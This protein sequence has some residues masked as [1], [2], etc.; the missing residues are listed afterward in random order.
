MAKLTH[1]LRQSL[2]LLCRGLFSISLEREFVQKGK[3]LLVKG[4][5]SKL[6]VEPGIRRH[7]R[8]VC[9]RRAGS[10]PLKWRKGENSSCLQDHE[11]SK[12]LLSKLSAERAGLLLVE[13]LLICISVIKVSLS[14]PK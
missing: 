10:V 9:R 3:G 2:W 7:R 13:S 14:G 11:A 6:G 8:T 5:H 4:T 12:D 1:G